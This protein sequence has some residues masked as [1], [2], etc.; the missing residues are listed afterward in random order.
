MRAFAWLSIAVLGLG[1]SSADFTVPATDAGTSDGAPPGPCDPEPGVAK[2]CVDVDLIAPRP[3]YDGASLASKL[4]IDGKGVLD[5]YLYDQDPS[6]ETGSSTSN[7]PLPV[8]TLSLPKKAGDEIALDKDFPA[9]LSGTAV[10]KDY[11]VVAVFKD[12]K[13][14]TRPADNGGLFP[15]DFLQVPEVTTKKSNFPK[16]TLQDGK[17]TNVKLT[18]RPY[19]AVTANLSVSNDLHLIASGNPTIHG[20]GPMLFLLYD[21]TAKLSTDPA[22]LSMS[23]VP[24]VSLKP[25]APTPPTPQVSFGTWAEGGL[26]VVGV[27][28]DY[29]GTTFPTPNTITSNMTSPPV[30]QISPS[31][32]A[33]TVS[34]PMTA[35]LNVYPATTTHAD[36]Y[37]CP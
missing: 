7:A 2:Y 9:K 30:V 11:W 25:G 10:A 8:A 1:C 4:D 17:V 5:V 16:I 19:R 12:N 22:P 14:A 37:V 33:T 36:P 29:P 32:W 6:P 21:G 15:G 24:C 3:N 31:T 23:S 13:T 28:L 26:Q 34:L 35:V 20:D 18:L 27:L